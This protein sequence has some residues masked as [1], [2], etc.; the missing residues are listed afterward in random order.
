MEET[1]AV[2]GKTYRKFLALGL[3]FMVV[4]FAMMILQPLGREPSLILAV[5]LFIVAFIPLEFAR[6]IA[7]K[8]AMVAFR[9]NRKA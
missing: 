1:L 3:G 4:A 6:R 5:I 9:V 2:M 7:R 8:M